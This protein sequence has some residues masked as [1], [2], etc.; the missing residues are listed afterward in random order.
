MRSLIVTQ[1]K[2]LRIQFENGIISKDNKAH[3]WKDKIKEWRKTDFASYRVAYET[4]LRSEP[5]HAHLIKER[6]EEVLSGRCSDGRRTQRKLVSDNLKTGFSINLPLFT[7][8]R[9][10]Q[11]VGCYAAIPYNKIM[12]A[13]S[14]LKSLWV[15]DALVEQP[16]QAAES[17][18]R[19]LHRGK[20]RK[21][22]YSPKLDAYILRINGSGDLTPQV[23]TAL[24]KV[25]EGT[26][27]YA[28]RWG[29]PVTF[30]VFSRKPQMQ[31]LLLRSLADQDRQRVSIRHSYDGTASELAESNRR[32]DILQHSEH[33]QSGKIRL[34]QWVKEGDHKH[35][36]ADIYFPDHKTVNRI[37]ADDRDC[38][39]VRFHDSDN[40]CAKCAICFEPEPAGRRIQLRVA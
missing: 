4:W 31:L 37:E 17:I 38:P 21:Y 11:C 10:A 33:W 26:R 18:I 7:C 5:F 36:D 28:R 24:V 39:A 23:I 27:D 30:A 25:I 2:E 1:L 34:V 6:K 12:L 22:C 32:V 19:Y 40:A 16:D 13:E 29:K 8:Q 14:V 20:F 9:Q 15:Y 3:I 35:P